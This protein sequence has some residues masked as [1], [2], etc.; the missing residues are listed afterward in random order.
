VIKVKKEKEKRDDAGPFEPL[1][2]RLIVKRRS[3]F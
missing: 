1:T 2:I 3:G